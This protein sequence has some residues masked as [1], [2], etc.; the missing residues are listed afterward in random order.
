[1]KKFLG[2]T[3]LMSFIAF[4]CFSQSA[5]FIPQKT[6]NVLVII[7]DNSYSYS[8]SSYVP[9][10]PDWGYQYS[11]M[12]AMQA[13]YDNAH[14]SISREYW[15]LK[16][17]ELVNIYNKAY[18]KK[19]KD[20]RLPWVERNIK[21]ADITQASVYQTFIDNITEVFKDPEISSEIKLLQSCYTELNRIKY[22]DPDNYIYSK[23]YKAICKTL[24]DLENCAKSQIKN[25]S[26]EGTELG[27]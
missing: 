3:F 22:K 11:G 8:N 1:M 15:K 9:Y 21:N 10:S 12:A 5:S 16:N 17:L 13:R 4:M 19:F 25:L 23:R 26:W 18:L 20:V 2:V 7:Y 27:M 24:S 6:L 14:A